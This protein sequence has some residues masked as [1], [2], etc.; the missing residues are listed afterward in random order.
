MM[1]AA[2]QIRAV[3]DTGGGGRVPPSDL[4]AEAAVLSAILLDP[5]SFD[6][7]QEILQPTHFYADANRR[8]WDVIIELDSVGKA[9]TTV[10]VA[11]MLRDRDQLQQIGGAPYLAQLTDCTPATMYVE[12]AATRVAEKARQRA[13]IGVCQHYAAEGYGDV[14]D[15]TTW[16]Q[17]A[18]QKLADVAAKGEEEDPAELLAEIMPNTIDVRRERAARKVE[19]SGVDTGLTVL[20]KLVGGWQ[21]GKLHV[22]GGRPGMGKTTFAL[23]QAIAVAKQGLGAIFISAEMTKEELVWKA[24]AAEARVDHKLVKSGVMHEDQ[25]PA[26][27]RAAREL[28]VLPLSLK[29]RSGATIPLIRSTI[30]KEQRRLQQRG[31]ERLGLIVVDYLQIL[32]GQRE[33]GESRE[34]EIAQISKRLMWLAGEFETPVLALSQL[35]RGVESRANANKRPGMAD[36]RESGAIEQD[37]YTITLLYRDEYYN[38]ASQHK[39]VVEAIVVKNRGGPDGKAYLKFTAEYGRIDNLADDYEYYDEQD[40]AA[41]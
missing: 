19:I 18:A 26:V 6:R 17:D 30:R 14:G 7:V 29:H 16:A 24:L 38:K 40:A 34:N 4:D 22:V 9:P 28:A 3:P 25:W 35:N 2:E 10:A 31:V 27:V 20:N 36:L 1:G 37:A 41:E 39:G 11:G 23:S 12:Q 8:V 5:D 13:V 33:R 15:V 21:W 32:D